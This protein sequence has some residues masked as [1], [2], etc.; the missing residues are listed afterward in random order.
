MTLARDLSYLPTSTSDRHG[1]PPDPTPRFVQAL[2]DRMRAD[3]IARRDPDTNTKPTAYP[4]RLR[5]SDAGKCA[6]A[7][8]YR[9]LRVPESDP[10]DLPGVWVTSL[11]T[12]IHEAWQAVI[13]DLYPDAEIEPKLQIEGLD[14]S[15]HADAVIELNGR[16]I[17][18]ELKTKGGF[19][20]KLMVGERGAPE[21]PSFENMAQTALNAKA[22][23]ADEA[24]IGYLATEAISKPAA[25]RKHI[26]ELAR[27]A[28]EWTLTRDEWEPIADA[29]IARLQGILDLLDAGT[30]PARKIPNPEVPAKAVITDP[31]K[32]IWQVIEDDQIVDTGSWWACGYCP[33]R[34]ICASTSSGRAPI[35][36]VV[37]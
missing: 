16:T 28:S 12:M 36:E 1:N 6:R 3:E 13:A 27:F 32:G 30:L 31:S 24:V 4:T 2:V 9:A 17:L 26:G 25:A 22:V 35:T 18:F 20:Y 8:A 19:G 10:M 15:G 23:D 14:A 29:E 5:H 33:W 11:G 37:S 34:T 21:G 7:I